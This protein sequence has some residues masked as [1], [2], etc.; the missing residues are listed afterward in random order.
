MTKATGPN[1]QVHFRRRRDGKTDYSKRLALLKSNVARMV[2]R[3]SNR[4]VYVQL[5]NGG[6][7]EGGD[8][9]VCSFNSSDLKEFGFQ[10]KQNT[11]SA[12]LAAL[13]CGKKALKAGVKEFILDIGLQK[14]SKGSVIFAALKGAVDAGLQTSFGEKVLPSQ[15]RIEGKHLNVQGFDEAKKKILA[16]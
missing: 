13:A 7:S 1:Y 14:A 12:Y 2:V 8:K 9:C 4:F 5:F 15:D 3:K 10:G 6:F 16:L 11:P